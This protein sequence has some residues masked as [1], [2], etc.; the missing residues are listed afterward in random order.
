MERKIAQLLNDANRHGVKDDYL[1]DVMRDY[2]VYSKVSV[3]K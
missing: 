3:V 1:T 2:F